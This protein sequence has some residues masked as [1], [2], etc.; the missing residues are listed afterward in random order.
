MIEAQLLEKIA[1]TLY[2]D[3]D[4]AAKKRVILSDVSLYFTDGSGA[5]AAAWLQDRPNRTI[6]EAALIF[7]V[8]EITVS[9]A[10]ARG[11][12]PAYAG[13][14]A[15][16]PDAPPRQYVGKARQAAA[17]LQDRPNR[18][19]REAATLFGVSVA[20]IAVAK[21]AGP[22]PA[23]TGPHEAIPDAPPRNRGAAKQAAAWLQDRPFTTIKTAARLF[24]VTYGAVAAARQNGPYAPYEGPHDAVPDAVPGNLATIIEAAEWA[25]VHPGMPLSEVAKGHGVKLGDLRRWIGRGVAPR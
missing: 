10:K 13:P 1:T 14:Y 22:F 16:I 17:W 7:G 20:A 24:G 3:M 12:Y 5:Q 11:P 6:K 25:A 8:A 23:Y 9:K 19:A 15:G 4:R 2:S 21:R 18:T